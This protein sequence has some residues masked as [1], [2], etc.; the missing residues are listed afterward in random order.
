MRFSPRLLCETR[1]CGARAGHSSPRSRRPFLPSARRTPLRLRYHP[2]EGADLSGEMPV[3][4]PRYIPFATSGAGDRACR[5]SR[6]RFASR[7]RSIRMW[8]AF[9]GVEMAGREEVAVSSTS[10]PFAPP[11][12]AR[13]LQRARATNGRCAAAA[14]SAT[15]EPA[16][17]RLE[18]RDGSSVDRRCP[19]AGAAPASA[20]QFRPV[21]VSTAHD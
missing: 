19:A 1:L 18:A 20:V 11:R 2:E 15:N 3:A 5:A 17:R 9:G 8:R 16:A 12:R 10:P 14:G 6:S 13:R 7:S 21:L 4:T